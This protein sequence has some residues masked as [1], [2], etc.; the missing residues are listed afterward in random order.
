MVPAVPAGRRRTDHIHEG[1]T[2]ALV[3]RDL[4]VEGNVAHP[5]VETG[6]GLGEGLG[7]ELD[8]HGA[9]LVVEAQ[10]APFVFGCAGYVGWWKARRRPRHLGQL[11]DGM[12]H[13][14]V[15]KLLVRVRSRHVGHGAELVKG[16]VASAERLRQMWCLP[17]LVSDVRVARAVGPA[18]P[19]RS[20]THDSME[21]EPSS[22]NASRRP[23]SPKR[24][25]MAPS[26]ADFCTKSASKRALSSSF[27]SPA[28]SPI[29]SF[30]V[31]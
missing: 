7:R 10:V 22:R 1:V 26:I 3:Q 2:A 17:G 23:T 16:E 14:L 27:E 8:R 30:T 19:N 24:I 28:A 20:T 18:I 15:P 29:A 21:V 6:L 13:R 11:A 5:S 12:F 31:G 25:T 9:A 4:P